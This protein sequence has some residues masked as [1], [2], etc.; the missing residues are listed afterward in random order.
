MQQR[1][2]DFFTGSEVEDIDYK[3][4]PQSP[5]TQTV[6]V[7]VPYQFDPSDNFGSIP[8]LPNPDIV[9]VDELTKHRQVPPIDLLSPRHFPKKTSTL[10][11]FMIGKMEFFKVGKYYVATEDLWP[12]VEDKFVKGKRVHDFSVL[13]GR[14]YFG[15]EAAK[16]VAFIQGLIVPTSRQWNYIIDQIYPGGKPDADKW[17][18]ES[19]LQRQLD[20][21]FAG[22]FMGN[23][24]EM[25]VLHGQK[26]TYPCASFLNPLISATNIDAIHVTSDGRHQRPGYYYT[27][28]FYAYRCIASWARLTKFKKSIT[29]VA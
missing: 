27:S 1:R 25:Q 14:A 16:R 9:V 15:P 18:P 29:R 5:S 11:R 17:Y 21:D 10:P 4:V 13:D 6:P 26:G 12:T 23:L 20:L 24:H 2:N 7:G 19:N 22:G 8:I 3:S 28:K